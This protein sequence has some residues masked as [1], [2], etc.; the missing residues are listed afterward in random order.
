M[1]SDPAG[2][3]A[4][5]LKARQPRTLTFRIGRSNDNTAQ[6]LGQFAPGAVL[7]ANGALLIQES[8]ASVMSMRSCLLEKAVVNPEWFH[9]RLFQVRACLRMARIDEE[10]GG[11][12]DDG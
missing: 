4:A 2:H 10:I 3:I 12:R 1:F 6:A 11:V 9:G 8:V 7:R 5:A